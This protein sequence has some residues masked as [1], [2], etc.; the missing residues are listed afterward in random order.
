MNFNNLTVE[1]YAAFILAIIFSVINIAGFIYFAKNK[2]ISKFVSVLISLILPALAIF[3]WVYLILNV[4]GYQ[5]TTALYISLGSAAGYVVVATCVALV[6][7]AIIKARKNKKETAEQEIAESTVETVEEAPVEETVETMLLVAP[8]ETV[9]ETVEQP[10][11]ETEVA[12]ETE[13]AEVEGVEEQPAE[14]AIEQSLEESQ[15]LVAEEIVETFEEEVEES[16][17]EE[18]VEEQT[19]EIIE[20]VSDVVEQPVEEPIETE[21]DEESDEDGENVVT[22]QLSVN[23]VNGPKR[24]FEELLA[25]MDEEKR[26]YYDEVLAYALD[27]PKAKQVNTKFN[28]VVKIGSMRILFAKFV[29]TTMVCKFMAGSSELK[30]YSQE[31]KDVKI[32]EKPVIIELTSEESVDAAKRMIDIVFKNILDAKAEK[33][34]ARKALKEQANQE[35]VETEETEETPNEE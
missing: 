27:K 18:P 1:G 15:E 26:A 30:N 17:P 21:E 3:F 28:V 19:E 29:K 12:K 16:Q 6:I 32:K 35:T 8:E 31:E 10:L 13:L 14:E 23:F 33:K 9:V 4:I 20:E 7:N 5:L 22:R 25:E 34:A 11:E 24:P 2:E